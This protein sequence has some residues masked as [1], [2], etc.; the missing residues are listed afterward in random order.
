M[1]RNR[2]LGVSIAGMIGAAIA[3][4]FDRPVTVMLCS[5]IVLLGAIGAINDWKG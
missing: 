1:T 2:W 5:A 4:T 3:H